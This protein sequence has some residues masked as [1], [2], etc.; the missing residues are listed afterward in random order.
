[1]LDMQDT[2]NLVYTTSYSEQ[3]GFCDR[4]IN[5]LVTCLDDWLIK[6]VDMQNRGGYM[7][8]DTYVQ[9]NDTN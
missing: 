6:R 5:G 3:L 1:M 2:D 9:Y 4:H 8:L 7:I